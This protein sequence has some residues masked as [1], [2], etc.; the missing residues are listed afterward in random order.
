MQDAFVQHLF[1]GNV[2]V[3]LGSPSYD[4]FEGYTSAPSFQFPTNY[5]GF[6]FPNHQSQVSSISIFRG[7]PGSWYFSMIY[8]ICFLFIL[9]L[10][11]TRIVFV[12]TLPIQ[13]YHASNHYSTSGSGRVCSN[14]S[15][16]CLKVKASC[17]LRCGA[18]V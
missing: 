12:P 3:T 2:W 18:S 14:L 15:A 11:S 4:F 5:P 13:L 6:Q 17:T 7:I 8:A 9:F 1:R 16:R 10:N